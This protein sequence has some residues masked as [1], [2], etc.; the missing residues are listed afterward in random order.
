MRSGYEPVCQ[1]AMGSGNSFLLLDLAVK[2]RTFG[3]NSSHPM[4]R[5]LKF[6]ALLII[7]ATALILHVRPG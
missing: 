4:M 1:R 6:V 2:R 7:V 5:K 3:S